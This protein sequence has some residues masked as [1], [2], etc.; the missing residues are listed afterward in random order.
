MNRALATVLALLALL[1]MATTAAAQEDPAP[2]PAENGSITME[3]IDQTFDLA[4]NGTIRLTYRLIGDLDTVAEIAP[5]PPA[6]TTTIA[7][8]STDATG[9]PATTDDAGDAVV[10]APPVVL[11]ARVLNYASLTDPDDLIGVIGPDP[12][13][14]SLTSVIDGIDIVDIRSSIT[15]ESPTEA[16]L[17]LAVRTDTDVSVADRLE[18]NSDGIH[19]IV[20]QLRADEQVIARHGTVVE[21]RSD[22]PATPPTIDLALF[23]AVEDP[24]PTGSESEVDDA[25]DAFVGLVDDTDE[26]GVGLTLAIPPS[27]VTAAV[28]SGDIADNDSNLLADDVILA[29]PATPFDVSSAVAVGRVDAFTRQLR[30]GEDEVTR[31][32]GQTPSRDIWSTTTELSAPGAQALRDLGVRYLAMPPEIYRSTIATDPDAEIP[33]IDR[34][35]QLPLPDGGQMPVLVLDDELGSEFTTESTSDI[36]AEMTATEWAVGT[37]A[38]LRLAQYSA[39]LDER[40]AA[41]SHLIATP[42]LGPFDPRLLVELEEFSSSTDA[43]HFTLASDLTS[44]TA[45]VST[46]TDPQLPD[47]AGPSLEDRLDRIADVSNELTPVASMLPEGDERP[48]DWLRRLDSFVS[49]AFDDATVD[50]ELDALLADAQKIRDGVVAPEPFT[51]TLTG[52][53]GEIDIRVGNELSEPVDVIVRVTSPRLDFPEGDV[54]VSLAPDDVTVVKVPVV[55][56]SNGTSPVTVEILTPSLDPLTEPVTLTSRFTALTGLG[57]VLTA[58]LLLILLTWWFSHWR[59]RRRAAASAA[60]DTLEPAA[61]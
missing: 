25:V 36:I 19:P 21:R 29:A 30:F 40:A 26:L 61:E 59:A 15:V 52:R 18:F 37:V 43:I 53:E 8:T 55:A 58:G 39:P 34:F 27:V 20:V 28:E 14:S 60:P 41:R 1:G 11:T 31:A 45:T 35:I 48:A 54:E 5:T 51:F 16:I 42:D 56:R 47:V 13:F 46:D 22:G 4:P 50:A 38:D 23:G 10:E 17:E 57:Q 2:L 44:E 12:R 33:A 6:P 7:P 24:G 32:I 3:L 49:T 9:D